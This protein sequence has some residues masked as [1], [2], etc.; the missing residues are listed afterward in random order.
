MLFQNRSPSIRVN[1]RDD[2]SVV[3]LAAMT[4]DV[5]DMDDTGTQAIIS[6]Q[7]ESADA[8]DAFNKPRLRRAIILKTLES[9]SEKI[10]FQIP[11]EQK[12]SLTKVYND[13]HTHGLL[14]FLTTS[15][16]SW[17]SLGQHG[18][19]PGAS[20]DVGQK[21]IKSLIL[22]STS[23]PRD[24]HQRPSKN[25]MGQIDYYCTDACTPVME[26]LLDELTWDSTVIQ[27]AVDKAMEGPLV[28]AM[29]THPG[30]HAAKDS[31][32]GYCYLNQAALAARL[33][34]SKHHFSRVAVLDIGAYGCLFSKSLMPVA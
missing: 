33:F 34:Q 1:M 15:W 19:D 5:I 18:R 9:K 6:P 21:G 24:P 14:E 4:P 30:H 32:G 26:T 11:S 7:D 22:S 17:E 2:P 27:T 12:D 13:I 23:L 31:F 25:V 10:S 20:L 28:Y 29:P 3:V 16:S 8:L